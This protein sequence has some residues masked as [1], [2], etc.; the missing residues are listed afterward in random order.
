MH[1]DGPQ[2]WDLKT[3]TRI[4]GAKVLFGRFLAYCALCAAG[5]ANTRFES[6]LYL[7]DESQ[8][9]TTGTDRK[10]RYCQ[11]LTSRVLLHVIS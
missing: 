7:P 11:S 6:A 3:N 9:L 5:F 8:I 2:V 4:R 1:G 10:V